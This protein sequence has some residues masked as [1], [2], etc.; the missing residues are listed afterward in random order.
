M[1]SSASHPDEVPMTSPGTHL[2]TIR[3][4][5]WVREKIGRAEEQVALPDGVTT[6]A[7]VIAWQQQRGPHFASAFAEPTAIRAALDRI[8][9]KP[10]AKIGTAR[11]IGFFPPMT[12][13]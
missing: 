7:D 12:G 2:I 13:G 3:Y 9:V 1:P 5:A 4:F 6:I 8:H 10:D 11:E